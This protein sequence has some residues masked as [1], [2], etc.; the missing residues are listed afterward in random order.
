MA[1][2]FFIS[3]E[4]DSGDDLAERV[5]NNLRKRYGD[6]VFLDRE[7]LEGNWGLK[8][9]K[10]IKNCEI[11]L[12]ILTPGAEISKNVQKEVEEAQSQGKSIIPCKS[13]ALGPWESLPWGLDEIDGVEF[14]TGGE[15]LREL[16]PK[17]RVV[18][19]NTELLG[20]TP[21]TKKEKSAIELLNGKYDWR[22]K[23]T[24]LKKSGLSAKQ[25]DTLVEK[26]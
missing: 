18:E 19:K 2:K 23:D 8:I 20:E 22:T 5:Y 12:V 13:K 11:F 17:I 3:Y 10:V 21:L 6:V 15:L 26:K 25:F 4:R 7:D 24:I 9:K 16:Y 14:R 1:K